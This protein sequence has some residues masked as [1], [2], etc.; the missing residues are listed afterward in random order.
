VCMVS[1]CLHRDY[2]TEELDLIERFDGQTEGIC[3][4]CGRELSEWN[5]RVLG[6]DPYMNDIHNESVFVD[7]C[8]ECFERSSDD[9]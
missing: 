5:P 4:I 2:T 9:I 1:G 3:G 7:G 8:Q 6:F